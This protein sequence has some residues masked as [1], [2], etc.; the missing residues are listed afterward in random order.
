MIFRTL[1]AKLLAYLAILH[2][3]FA[4]L[5]ALV[6]KEHP[7][8]LLGFEAFFLLSAAAGW[9]L[10]RGVG[11]P[12]DLAR[13]GADLLRE[14]DFTTR[15]RPGAHA[16]INALIRV[17][18]AMAERLREEGIRLEERNLFIERVVRASPTAVLILDHDGLLADLNPA[19]E[20]LLG[21]QPEELLGRS[22]DSIP[23]PLAPELQTLKTDE[24]RVAGVGGRRLSLRRAEFYDRGAPRAFL[25][26]DELTQ[27]LREIERAAY[28][29]VI[30]MM[31]HEVRNS[32]G[33]V[34]SLLDSCRVYTPQL[35]PPDR[36]DAGLALEVS[37]R[38]LENLNAFMDGLASVVR[39]PDPERRPCDVLDLIRDLLTLLA[40]ELEQRCIVVHWEIED[41]LAAVS[42]DK[43]QFEQ[44]LINGL[45]NAIEAIGNQGR[46]VIASGKNSLGSWLAIRDSG[47]GLPEEVRRDLMTPFFTTKSEG[48]GVGLT[49]SREIL[50]RH[51]FRFDLA[52]HP[53]GGAEF[54]IHFRP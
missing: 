53:Q 29:K 15:F 35:R 27:E 36:Q 34:R 26:I 33:A 48:R 14:Q 46:I 51:G 11:L 54:L 50:A 5:A 25:L 9:A 12:L 52:N 42:L 4:V 30:R 2:L 13:T 23:H 22:L 43:N 17:Y 19:A 7:L 6:L 39:V 16:E 49:L 41:P 31:S 28:G 1:R 20:R 24:V 44:V 38:R 10:L 45:R 3:C 40:P 47:P 21:I 18:N 37:A 32:V 8:W